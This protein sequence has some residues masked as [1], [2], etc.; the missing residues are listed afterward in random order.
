MSRPGIAF[1]QLDIPE[2]L[3]LHNTLAQ[4]SGEPTKKTWTGS[5]MD[6]IQRVAILRTL[7]FKKAK[8]VLAP[9]KTAEEKD[10]ARPLSLFILNALAIVDHF[11]DA[12]TGAT[13]TQ[14]EA[15]RRSRKSVVS[16]GLTYADVLKLVLERFPHARTSTVMLRQMAWQVRHREPKN[17]ITAEDFDHCTLPDKRPTKRKETI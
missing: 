13:L 7:P 6:L 9:P 4:Q 15:A 16:V 17:G 1:S 12:A 14:A 10:R 5:R 8:A 3:A 2:L 11:E